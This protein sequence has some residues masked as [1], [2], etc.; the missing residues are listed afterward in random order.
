MAQLSTSSRDLGI[1]FFAVQKLAFVRDGVEERVL[2]LAVFVVEPSGEFKRLSP[3][4]IGSISRLV[5]SAER[6]VRP[7]EPTTRAV[8]RENTERA[9]LADL[10]QTGSADSAGVVDAIWPICWFI[11][12]SASALKLSEDKS[13]ERAPVI[14]HA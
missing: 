6:Q 14:G 4:Q 5:L 10:R 9:I 8:M 13:T 1:A 3:A 12:S 7:S 2:E 11:A